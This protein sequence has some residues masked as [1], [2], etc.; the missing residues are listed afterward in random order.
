M[1]TE[2]TCFVISPIGA[3]GSDVREHANAVFK[4]IIEPATTARGIRPVRAD[5]FREPGRITD[6]MYRH[7]LNDD[8]CIA[9][10]TGGNPNVYYELA[11][12]QSAARPI[13][14]LQQVGE[15]V[16]FDIQD[17]RF[18]EYDFLPKRLV[19][20]QVYATRLIEHIDAIA[21]AGWTVTCPIPGMSEAWARNAE[22]DFFAQS[23]SF[24]PH[25]KW[26]GLLQDT[27]EKFFIMGITLRT[28]LE[29][30]DLA[31]VLLRKSAE[32]CD[33]R[34]LL[35]HPDNP[36]L[37]LLIHQG[38]PDERL[39]KTRLD[40]AEVYSFFGLLAEKG[41]NIQ[42]RQAMTGC[43]MSQITVADHSATLIPYLFSAKSSASPLYH[44]GAHSPLYRRA[45]KEFEALWDAN[46]T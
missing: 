15:P 19:D 12:A 25:A 9:L 37:P 31:E 29:G 45:L 28:W 22:L 23:S 4:Y 39:A 44:T 8:L 38:R 43:T 2:R 13:V 17:Y 20:D 1:P 6:D 10:L 35:M 5:Q 24:G 42:V 16:P 3:S 27:S 36:A 21:D 11:V 34:V 7:I 33:V 18:V 26:M 41:A 30:E 14:M 32:G 40:I 46:A